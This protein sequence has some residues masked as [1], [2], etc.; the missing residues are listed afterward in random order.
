[1][2]K[3]LL[4]IETEREEK[5]IEKLDTKQIQR[6]KYTLKTRFQSMPETQ[7]ITN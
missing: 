4:T 5:K 6:H 2:T 3:T 7:N 1:M